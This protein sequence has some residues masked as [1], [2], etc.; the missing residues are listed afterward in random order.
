MVLNVNMQNAKSFKD[1]SVKRKFNNV[2]NIY[3]AFKEEG[4]SLIYRV[5]ANVQEEDKTTVYNTISEGYEVVK[6]LS[7]E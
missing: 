6:V 4:T 3:I 2:R 1:L 7:N 5:I